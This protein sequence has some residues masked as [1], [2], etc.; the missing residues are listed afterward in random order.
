MLDKA[1]ID[2]LEDHEAP[3]VSGLAHRMLGETQ[4]SPRRHPQARY[5]RQGRGEETSFC[6]ILIK[7]IFFLQVLT[8]KLRSDGSGGGA[9]GTTPESS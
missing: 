7:E 2:G 9:T 4:Q 8:M 5:T 1:Q 6:G 3:S